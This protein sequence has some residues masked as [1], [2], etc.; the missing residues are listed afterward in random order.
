MPTLGWFAGEKDVGTDRRFSS[1]GEGDIGEGGVGANLSIGLSNEP[2]ESPHAERLNDAHGHSVGTRQGLEAIDLARLETRSGGAHSDKGLSGDG[3]APYAGQFGEES[4]NL[5]DDG[6]CE[7]SLEP[8]RAAAPPREL[9]ESMDGGTG[10]ESILDLAEV[11]DACEAE[12]VVESGRDGGGYCSRNDG[13]STGVL[14]SQDGSRGDAGVSTGA[15]SMGENSNDEDGDR[16]CV[17]Y[18]PDGSGQFLE[19]VDGE[20]PGGAFVVSVLVAA[21]V[22]EKMKPRQ[23]GSAGSG[24]PELEAASQGTQIFGEGL[25]GDALER[26]AP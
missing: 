10:G 20:A 14:G 15:S 21:T 23:E 5:R 13:V 7:S 17:Y 11:S 4:R 24:G 2:M 6:R 1:L 19:I 12:H 26:S 18:M 22:G 16:V 25:A 8:S 9:R 3:G